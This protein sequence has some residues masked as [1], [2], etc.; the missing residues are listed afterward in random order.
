MVAL[1]QPSREMAAEAQPM[2]PALARRWFDRVPLPTLRTVLLFAAAGIPTLFAV[3]W[4][5][6]S[7]VALVLWAVLG[8]AFALDAQQLRAASV[9]GC[10]AVPEMMLAHTPNRLV[11]ELQNAGRRR[12]TGRWLDALPDGD[13]TGA[14]ALAPNERL[15]ISF[16]TAPPRGDLELADV[17]LAIEGPWRLA[18][19]HLCVEAR[20][21]TRAL[22]D[23]REPGDALPLLRA[24]L[25][26]G[27][28]RL[29]RLGEGREFDALRP[30]RAGD[31]LRSVDW[32]ASARRAELVARE[33][34]PE[35]NQ[36]VLL[37]VD[38][39]RHFVA[40]ER[41]RS[42]F[43]HSLQAALRLGR[44]ALEHGDAVG[45]LAFGGQLRSAIAPAK[46]R[47]HLRSLVEATYRLQPELEESD[48]AAAFDWVSRVT[49]RRALVCAFTDLVD[50]DAS[51]IL[52]ART[53]ALRPKHLPVMVALL[54][55]E[56]AAL[57]AE[58][59]QDEEATYARAAAVRLLRARGEAMRRLR[60]AG[61]TVVDA[62]SEKVA[63]E[64][65]AAYLRIKE[66]GLL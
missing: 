24:R 46:G 14:F 45:L 4:P 48:Y 27:L 51:R 62:P 53:A 16:E 6:A 63:G 8:F 57:E 56:L 1:S 50:E 32:K 61:V 30:Y 44:S 66:R 18:A 49:T 13:R 40:R 33:Y 41:D 23:L 55:G 15:E 35:K 20:G 43:D 17:F 12:F 38:C 37:L 25:E 42:R 26:P 64:A 52:V 47:A 7:L 19:R 22:P 60:D 39:G 54:D 31:D 9:L 11:L 29:R 59:P 10:R 2:R 58:A 28:A 3:I 5:A 65:I 21:R 34:V 36:A